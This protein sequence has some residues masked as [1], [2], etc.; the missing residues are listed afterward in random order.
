ME[1]KLVK[2]GRDAL[3]VTLPAKWIQKRNLKAGDSVYI[4]FNGKDLSVKSKEA[5]PSMEVTVDVTGEE[6]SMIWHTIIAKYIAGY[7]RIIILHSNP[8]LTQHFTH[9]LLGMIIEDHSIN[10]TVLKTIISSPESDIDV[11]IRRVVHM[12]L[13]QAELY[14]EYTLGKATFD[15][16]RAQERLIDTNIYYCLRFINK[17]NLHEGSYTYFLLCSTIEEAA[18]VLTVIAK[19]SKDSRLASGIRSMIDSFNKYFFAGD[20]KKVYTRL[21]GFRDSLKKKTFIDGIAYELAEVLYN[22][23]GILM[24]STGKKKSD[25]VVITK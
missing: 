1:R 18:D 3:T 2:Q 13:H 7:D 5:S 16:V 23:I 25:N 17:Y 12:F 8:S 9:Y 14:E 21:R 15:D 19:H 10:K 22:N 4:D 6:R 11:I 20:L 24:E